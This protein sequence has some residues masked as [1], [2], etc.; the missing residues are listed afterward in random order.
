ML[1]IAKVRKKS[2]PARDG[3]KNPAKTS[4]NWGKPEESAQNQFDDGGV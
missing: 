3:R 4:K 2:F 1:G